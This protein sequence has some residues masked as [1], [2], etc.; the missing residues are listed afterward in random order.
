MAYYQL[1]V[2]APDVEGVQRK[3]IEFFVK[4]GR[5]IEKK[6]E[7][8]G[9]RS[10]AMVAF[11]KVLQHDSWPRT[12]DYGAY[13]ARVSGA[14]QSFKDELLV[15]KDALPDA[16]RYAMAY[17]VVDGVPEDAWCV[18]YADRMMEHIVRRCDY[19]TVF[20][21]LRKADKHNFWREMLL[22][23]E[24]LREDPKAPAQGSPESTDSGIARNVMRSILQREI[25]CRFPRSDLVVMQSQLLALKN[26]SLMDI[27]YGA[28]TIFVPTPAKD[29]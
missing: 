14:A 17:R 15:A 23:G 6:E 10:L 16:P 13:R 19:L 29:S 21:S 11:E 28:S 26:P 22:V 25:V 20:N 24:D 9:I 1:E 5:C 7:L 3:T 8:E 18:A 2:Q 12:R 4:S 27:C